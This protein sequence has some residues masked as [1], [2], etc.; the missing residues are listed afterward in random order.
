MENLMGFAEV[1]G[2]IFMSFAVALTLQWIG[3]VVL[4]RLMPGRKAKSMSAESAGNGL[5][6]GVVELSLVP[7]GRKN[8]A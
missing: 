2:A 6:R 7:R 8:A 4:M 5:R 1:G 3:L